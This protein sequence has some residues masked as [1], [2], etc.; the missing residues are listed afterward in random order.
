MIEPHDLDLR[1][2]EGKSVVFFLQA[3]TSAFGNISEITFASYSKQPG[4]S[5]RLSR[6]LEMG[7]EQFLAELTQ[8]SST[9][10]AP[11]WS[12]FPHLALKNRKHVDFFVDNGLTHFHGL[13]AERYTVLAE[14]LR[15]NGIGGVTKHLPS[16]HGL[17]VCS[18]IK[19]TNGA[20]MHM[21]MMDFSIAPSDASQQLLLTILGKVGQ[22]KGILVNS[23]NSYH[24]YGCALMKEDEWRAFLGQSL[25][26]SP[27]TD[28]R[29]IAHRLVDGYCSLRIL[30]HV[31]GAMPV[32]S[33]AFPTG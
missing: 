11:L 9:I 7:D 6:Y 19:L 33:A 4:L 22:E 3:F 2:L 25:L 17:S 15:T 14:D 13:K 26:L 31:G 27:I 5:S 24:F 29:Y 10:N 1:G 8:A 20:R 12:I 30:D 18:D 32:I 23:G 21:P 28:S 16:E